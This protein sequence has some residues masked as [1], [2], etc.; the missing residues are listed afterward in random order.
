MTKRQKEIFGLLLIVFSL[1][2]FISLF[3]HDITENPKG[4]LSGYQPNNYL[5]YFGVYIS[6]YHYLLLGYSS[7]IFPIIFSILG[8]LIFSGQKIKGGIKLSAFIFLIALLF[9]IFMSL[10]GYVNNNLLL[11]NYLSGIIGYTLFVFIK[12]YIGVIGLSIFLFISFILLVTYIYEISIYK[13]FKKTFD[14]SK[15]LIHKI[16]NYLKVIF[17]FSLNIL[18]KKNEK[19]IHIVDN[20]VNNLDDKNEQDDFSNNLKSLDESA[21]EVNSNLDDNLKS[22]D[23]SND[24]V[25]IGSD[26]NLKSF[27]QNISEDSSNPL[28]VNTDENSNMAIDKEEE[29]VEGDLDKKHKE[30][31][32]YFQYKLPNLS[33]L[34]DPIKIVREN[35]DELRDKGRQLQYTLKTFGVEGEVKNVSPG[36]VISL[37]EI[38]PAVGV[39]VNKFIN[40]SDDIARVMKAQR[41]RIIAPIPGSKSVGIELPNENISTVYLKSILNSQKFIDSKSKL[42]IALGKTTS[43]DAYIFDLCKMPHLLVA[44]ATGSGKSVC[45][46]TI[47]LSILYKAKPDEVKFILLDP[48]K[49]ELSTYKSLV[50]YH[51][52]TSSNLDEYVMTT[53]ENSVAIL[54][55]AIIEMERRFQV[56]SDARVRN[57]AEYHVKQKA[58]D[59][60]EKVPYI[61]VLIDELADLMMTSGR[62][63]EEPIT[64]LAQKARAVGIHLVVATQRPS[65]DVITGLI[66]SNFP[67]RISFL[68]SS[69]IDSRTILDQMGAEKLLGRGDM[70]FL[71]PGSASPIRLHNAFVTL[72]EIEKIMTHISSQPKPNEIKLPEYEVK[73]S[74]TDISLDGDHDELLKDAAKLVVDY[75]QAS[76]SLLQRKFRIG[77]SRAG[78]LIDELESLGIVSSYNGSKAREILVDPSYLDEIFD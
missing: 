44:G 62:A 35:N 33:Y 17:N 77:Y 3:G 11:S 37:Y 16:Y 76:V 36:P 38:E 29:I 19:N 34:E 20:N 75:Q 47:I 39:R 41:V 51:L 45:I 30:E 65:V 43:G 72:E 68:V 26:D 57:I 53:A 28:E 8:Y 31:S 4:L 49:L 50:G 55:S 12:D 48:K 22:F 42:T 46:N 25:D 24:E 23:E 15:I 5:G 32:K 64:R 69:K 40:L 67:S 9:S 56:F 2:C 73:N 78:R 52:I 70:L 10:V 61:V 60:L 63:V 13:V 27:N 7:I 58:D 21:V 54:N 66:K 1:L 6:Y 74:N 18:K 59:K 71:L 14:F